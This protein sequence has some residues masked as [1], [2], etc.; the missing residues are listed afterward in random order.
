MVM[1]LTTRPE[2]SR[3]GALSAGLT[4]GTVS[5]MYHINRSGW[6]SKKRHPLLRHFRHWPGMQLVV[7][8]RRSGG[9]FAGD[10]AIKETLRYLSFEAWSRPK[11]RDDSANRIYLDTSL[12]QPGI[13]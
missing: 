6:I 11:E 13:E 7:R 12:R 3:L 5:V 8:L 2:R 9:S 10:G 4:G 1:M